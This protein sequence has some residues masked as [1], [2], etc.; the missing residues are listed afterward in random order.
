VSVCWS[1]CGGTATTLYLSRPWSRSFSI[2]QCSGLSCF[3]LLLKQT[4]ISTPAT[5]MKTGVQVAAAMLLIATP[6]LSSNATALGNATLPIASNATIRANFTLANSTFQDFA[7]LNSTSGNASISVNALS[8]TP[9]N[10]VGGAN[11]SIASYASAIAGLIFDAFTDL[12]ATLDNATFDSESVGYPEFDFSNLTTDQLI[13]QLNTSQIQSLELKLD[14]LIDHEF[15]GKTAST[16]EPPQNASASANT[17]VPHNGTITFSSLLA[18]SNTSALN[19]STTQNP[20]F[21]TFS[22]VQ[23]SSTPAHDSEITF[24]SLN[25]T[26]NSLSSSGTSASAVEIETVENAETLVHVVSHSLENAILTAIETIEQVAK[27]Q[28]QVQAVK[29]ATTQEST[30]IFTAANVPSSTSSNASS[31]SGTMWIPVAAAVGALV[32]I[33]GLAVVAVQKR[34]QRGYNTLSPTSSALAAL[35]PPRSFNA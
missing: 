17:T 12:N 15:D 25:D 26:S 28:D 14:T 21:A 31:A 9:V 3:V 19:T 8:T 13:Q 4:S 16:L 5:M 32:A 18:S 24:E 6:V 20:T 7:A 2:V 29:A 11:F 30:S 23:N 22:A 1:S 33:V 10:V 35:T 34:R 27:T